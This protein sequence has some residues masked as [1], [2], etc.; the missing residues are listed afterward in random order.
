[1]ILPEDF[2]FSASSLQD[3]VDCPRRFYL[4]HIRQ[5]RSPAPPSEPLRDF[6]TQVERGLRLHHLI[7][8]HQI[9]IAPKVLEASLSD[10]TLSAWWDAY[11]SDSPADLPP[12]RFAEVTLTTPLA[13]RRLV[14]RYDL[15]A[16]GDR[17]VIVDWKTALVRPTREKLECRLQ[18]VVYPYVLARAGAHLNGSQPIAPD[19]ITMIY[20][21]AEFPQQPEILT[22]SARQFQR[23]GDYLETLVSDILRR[24]EDEFE[25]TDSTDFCR[26]CAYR[27]LNG[28][29]AKAGNALATAGDDLSYDFA[30]ERTLDQI[31]EI[32]Y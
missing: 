4:R 8:Q 25:L 26:Y 12:N 29:G 32:G 20:W 28:R 6:E 21:F 27:S 5:L 2:Q 22:Y 24:S 13:G 7:H 10:G 15:L 23:D 19:D 30:I 1:M 17:A 14:A 16:L 9:G 3:F 18:T 31:V 11:L